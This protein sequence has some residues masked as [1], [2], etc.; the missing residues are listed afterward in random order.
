MAVPSRF[1]NWTKWKLVYSSERDGYSLTTLYNYSKL[2]H[3]PAILALRDEFD[4]LFGAYL[5]EKF[6][7]HMGHY[8]TGEWYCLWLNLVFFGRNR[9]EG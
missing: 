8:G 6:A 4:R 3:G 5:S 7:P 1:R 2:Q 9:M